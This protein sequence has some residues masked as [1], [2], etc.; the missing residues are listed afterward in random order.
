MRKVSCLLVILLLTLSVSR[1]QQDKVTPEPIP[2][3]VLQLPPTAPKHDVTDAYFGTKIVDPYRWM[4]DA[5]APDFEK[6]MKS[7]ADYT[8]AVLAALPGRAKLLERI[9]ELDNAGVEVATHLCD[10]SG[11]CI[12]VYGGRYFYLKALPG[13]T[14]LKLYVRETKSGQERLLFDPSKLMENGRHYALD[15]F[16]ASLDGKYVAYGISPGGSEE[17]VIHILDVDSGR[18]L[19]DTIDRANYASIS[20]LPDN[21][22]F[23]YLRLN[24]LGPNDPQ[25]AKYQRTRNYLHKLGRDAHKD[26]PVLGFGLSPQIAFGED[27]FPAAAFFPGSDW[28][29]GFVFHGVQNEL[30][31]FYAPLEKVNGASTPWRKLVDV[32]DDVTTAAVH[33]GDIYLLTHHGASRFKVVHT[34]LKHPDIAHAQ[35]VVPE[36]D[37]V[38]RDLGAASDAL[39]VRQLDGGIGR[40]LRVPYAGTK[41]AAAKTTQ[42][43]LPFEGAVNEM[44]TDPRGPGIMLRTQSWTISSAI[45]AYDPNTNSTTDLKL[46]PASPLD[47]S[48]IE[49]REVKAR[50]A[51]GT[52]VPLSIVYKR[53]IPMDGSSPTILY[54]YGSYGITLDPSFNPTWLAWLER[55][56]VWATAHVRGGGEYGEDWH[57]AGRKLTKQNTISDFIACAEYLIASKFTS[58]TRLGVMG[59]SA[60]GITVGG[61]I[62][63][64]P[65]LFAAA[66]DVVPA[67]DTLRIEISP[68]GPANIPEFGSVKT[69]EGF[70]GLYAMSAYHHIKDGTAYPAVIVV[71]GI[72]DPRVASWEPA[73]MA[74]R[75]Q[76]ATSS[77]KPVLLRVDFDAGHGMGSTRPQLEQETADIESFFLWQM[78]VQEFQPVETMPKTASADEP[79]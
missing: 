27:D 75:L 3:R 5:K 7:Q 39:Y 48:Q 36:G 26:D 42:V 17:S 18:E 58:S 8:N 59:R 30:T 61:A 43:P 40:V 15:Y 49:S 56:G 25:T 78:G 46:A 32:D 47:F 53:D 37:V 2:A 67:S 35:V 10:L 38:L 71:T 24:K 54:G 73:K 68:N 60:G 45:L 34:S 74:A 44:F 1:A 28:V 64:R 31:I 16:N 77:G 13:E 4:E 76:S 29:L 9:Q 69:E 65:E 62:T 66:A 22:S 20:W 50:S 52:M 12:Q 6:W 70:K 57:N 19:P 23:F 79:K 72:N 33:G 55:G 41:G 11:G 63:Q 21:R 14:M 51:D